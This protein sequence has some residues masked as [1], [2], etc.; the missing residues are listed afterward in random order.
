MLVPL[1]FMRNKLNINAVVDHGGAKTAA[2]GVENCDVAFTGNWCAA[3]DSPGSDSDEKSADA[4]KKIRKQT[5]AST[6]AN[7]GSTKDTSTGAAGL[8]RCVQHGALYSRPT[9]HGDSAPGTVST[10]L[11]NHII[12]L[13]L[14]HF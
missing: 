6:G 9:G 2:R 4:G 1:H 5:T 10:S 7:G 11:S 12:N 13:I 8:E 3:F 14:F